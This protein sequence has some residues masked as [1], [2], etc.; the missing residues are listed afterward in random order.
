GRGQRSIQRPRNERTRGGEYEGSLI[1]YSDWLGELTRPQR[2]DVTRRERQRK[3]YN[4][5]RMERAWIVV[6]ASLVWTGAASPAENLDSFRPSALR[7]DYGT[8]SEVQFST[9]L[10]ELEAGALAHHLPQAM[11]DF[12]FAEPVWVIGYKTEILDSHGKSPK[13]NY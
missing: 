7:S 4:G 6:V 3:V 10:V 9:G 1:D 2:A 11:K 5:A 8:V 13:E 12:R